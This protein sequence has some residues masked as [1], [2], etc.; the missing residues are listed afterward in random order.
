MGGLQIRVALV[1]GVAQPVVREGHGLAVEH[2][3]ECDV[4]VAALAAGGVHGVLVQVVA[5]VED[6]VDVVLRQVPVDGVVAVL[7]RLAGDGGQPERRGAV[8]RRGRGE[9]AARRA[10][11][12]PGAEAVVVPGGRFQAP[13]VDVHAVGVLRVGLGG[14]PLG[15]Q[16]E[17]LVL[18]HLPLHGD[19]LLAQPTV[20][21]ERLG[22]QPCPQHHGV[23]QGV[24]RGDAQGERVLVD[25]GRVALGR[26]DGTPGRQ[27]GGEGERG[28]RRG[29]GEEA[30]A[31]EVPGRRAQGGVVR[32][33]GVLGQCSVTARGRHL[34]SSRTGQ[35][36]DHAC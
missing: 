19:P 28:G 2:V 24:A 8:A 13:D 21:L 32:G 34:V 4:G 7:V 22:G 20:R 3:R 30:P 1:E 15:D 29:D 23:G 27:V 26:G 11:P 10:D 36:A 25:A 31:A 12:G 16:G 6:D 9:G 14:A 5:E 33:E 35:D 17:G 18:G